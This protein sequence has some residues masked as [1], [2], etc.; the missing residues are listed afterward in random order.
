MGL[1]K[2]HITIY[3]IVGK[4]LYNT[5]G[6]DW[7]SVTIYRGKTRGWEG[8]SKAGDVCIHVAYAC[9]MAEISTTL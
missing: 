1:K 3:Q 4:L 6:S 9:Y 5:G 8:G 2:I 7:Y